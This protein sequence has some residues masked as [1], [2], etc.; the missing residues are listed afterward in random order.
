MAASASTPPTGVDAHIRT[1]LIADVRGYTVFTQERGDE[2]AA[3]L[4]SRFALVAREVVESRDGTVVELRGDEALAVFDSARQAIRASIDLQR[5]FADE[6]VANPSLPLAVGIGLDAGEAVSVQGGYRGGALN[7][8]ARLCSIAGP[9]EI[10]ASPAVTHLARKVEGVAYVDRGTASLKG[11]AEPVHVIR[12]RAEA[13]DPADDVAFRRAL[14]VSGAVPSTPGAVAANPYKGLRAFEE[15]DAADFFGREELVAQIIERLGQTRFLA[16]VGPSGSGKSSVVRAGLLPAIRSGAIPGSA[17]WRIAD[18]FPG[19]HP[20]DGLEAALLRAV[21]DPPASL[22]DQLERDDHGL[23]RAVLRLLPA[24]GSELVLVIDQFEEVFTLV[25]DE[26]AR[27]HFLESIEVAA[28]DQRSRLRVVATLRADFYDRPLM[29]RGF[30]DLFKSRVE[31][32]VPLS[33]EEI[34]RALTGPAKRVDHSLEPGLVAAMLGDIAEEPGALPLMEYALT[35]LFERRDGRVLTLAAYRDIGGVSGALG[36]R[37]E[38]LYEALPD[39]GREAARQLFLRLVTLGEGT[40]DT[41]RRAFRSEVTSLDLD[42]KALTEVLDTF[43]G[44]RQLS[45]DRDARSGEPTIELAHE[46]IL[47]AWPRLHHWI[48]TAREDLRA[49]RRVSAAAAEWVAADRDPSFLLGGSRLDQAEA[50]MAESQL[51]VTPLEREY[52]AAGVAQRELQRAAAEARDLHERRLERRSRSRLRALVA[53]LTVAAL[54]ASA[55]TIVAVGQRGSAVEQT[56]LAFARELAA[57][58]QANLDVDPERSILLAM[59][60]VQATAED[61]LVLREAVDALHAAV[62]ADRLLFTMTDPSTGNVLWSPRGDLIATGGSVGGN[63]VNN[64]VL[65]DAHTG[66]EVRRL[67]GHEGDIESITFSDD[68]ATI[69]STS[70]DR[71]AR[72]WDAATGTQLASFTAEDYEGLPGASFSPDGQELILG[73]GC[74]NDGSP[75]RTALR[76]ID[77]RSWRVDRTFPVGPVEEYSAAPTYS[78]D[79]TRFVAESAIWDAESGERLVEMPGYQGIWRP[80]GAVVAQNDSQTEGIIMADATDGAVLDRLPVPGGVTGFAWSPDATLFATGGFD[81]IAR[82]FDATSGKEL[83]ALPGHQGL[84]GLVSFSPDGTKLVT[85]GGDGTARVWDVS[86]EGGAELQAAAYNTWLADVE[87]SPDGDTILTAGEGGWIWDAATLD[88][89]EALPDADS[90]I[91]I[92]PD[93]TLLAAA[94]YDDDGGEVRVIDVATDEVRST[95]PA[96]DQIAFSPDGSM[97]A[98]ANCCPLVRLW[99]TTS[100]ERSGDPLRDPDAPPEASQALG[101]S[102]DGSLLAVLDGRA[103]VRL[104]RT[105]DR[106]LVKEWQANSGIGKALAWDPRGDL[107]ATGGADGVQLWTGPD[108]ETGGTLAGGGLVNAMAFNGDGTRMAAVSDRSLITIWDTSSWQ[109]VLVLPTRD[110][111]LSGIAFSPDGASLATVSWSGQLRTY[112]LDLAQLLSIGSQRVSRS[113]TDEECL[114]YL[115]DPCTRG[116][117][118]GEHPAAAG[119]GPPTVL[120]GGYQVTITEQEGRAAGLDGETAFWVQGSYTLTLL[121]GTYRLTQIHPWEGGRTSWGTYEVSGDQLVLTA[122]SDAR[123]AGVRIEGTWQRDGASLTLHD[124]EVTETETCPDD[125]VTSVVFES[126]PWTRLGDLAA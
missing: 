4:A 79:G 1:F 114:Q 84:V 96:A 45:F 44:S 105:D 70:A 119:S 9:A 121:D 31:A 3:A 97:V 10:L 52:I 124:L 98:T 41:R 22:M 73:T 82:V 18:M 88:Q 95:L 47:V 59:E 33:A 28:T 90:A 56:R 25:E 116:E 13:D 87:Y 32:L 57:A 38:E 113:L 66:R 77:T 107:L 60:A 72:I 111:G 106:T 125:G 48:D 11:L 62:A 83:F 71:T 76:V 69:A 117:A 78:P 109:E 16:I 7:L 81:G 20:L 74:C 120:D 67:L 24:D 49:E 123:C 80:D 21:P 34:E 61:G 53:V 39:E 58:A 23:H 37:A 5:R 54:V 86:P 36:R 122:V 42:Q 115:H 17:S 64:V 26:D 6:T 50:W 92:S 29:Y 35:E 55:L 27:T 2:A 15:A 8:A 19:A 104:W 103:T 126:E 68:G 12:L 14:G 63:A 51:A 101:F 30:A 43:G 108:F 40:E 94:S 65:W 112:S 75:H 93:G 46:A 118:S 85:G 100:G 102:P 110:S 91:A 89:I 99:D